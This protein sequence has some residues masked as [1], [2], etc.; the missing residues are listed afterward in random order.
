M[1][2]R[3]ISFY[4]ETDFVDFYWWKFHDEKYSQFNITLQC[5]I[6]DVE[7]FIK[8]GFEKLQIAF[9]KSAEGEIG[10]RE[11]TGQSFTWG[12]DLLFKYYVN[13]DTKR[14]QF[15]IYWKTSEELD[16]IVK[17][18]IKK[19]QLMEIKHDAS[20]TIKMVIMEDGELTLRSFNI[21]I[22]IIDLELNYGLEWKEKHDKL[23]NILTSDY[24]KGIALL[25]GSP[26]TGK[27][28]YIR[29][30]ASL[31]N[32]H[33]DVIY[34]PNQ[35]INSI[36]DPSFLPLIADH[37]DSVIVIEDAED[38]LKSRKAGGYTVDKLLN[39]ADGII[40]DFLG[41][42]IICTFNSDVSLID[43]ALLRKGRLILKH[44]FKPL[45][46]EQSQSL[47]DKLGLK[48]EATGPMT[49]A[50]IYNVE[51]TLSEGAKASNRRPIGF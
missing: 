19:L 47:I 48:H 6:E 20:S 32:E 9:S 38:A 18:Y 3:N 24:K 42:Q 40:S 10:I 26:G 31:L 16:T 2:K 43:E 51:D 44:E 12:K 35:L 49:L 1:N 5:E 39:I 4:P 14:F 11:Y 45:T 25:H 15:Y 8:P 46:K 50:D 41:I 13:L 33:K 29:Y 34:L 23:F 36:T 28:V 22:P 37:P 27:S 17:T 21:N 7:R 30:L